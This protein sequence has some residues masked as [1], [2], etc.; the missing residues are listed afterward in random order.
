MPRG[1][2]GGPRDVEMRLHSAADREYA[3]CDAVMAC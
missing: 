1:R 2:G 3:I